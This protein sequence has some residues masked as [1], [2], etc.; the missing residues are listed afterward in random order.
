MGKALPWMLLAFTLGV[1]LPLQASVNGVL[2]QQIG[3]PV[4][5]AAVS[6]MV[7]TLCLI[8]YLFATRQSLPWPTVA[9]FNWTWLLSGA[10]G[11]CFVCL[12]LV[13]TPRLGFALSFGLVVAGQMT[14]AVVFDH[15]G[16]LG[17]PQHLVNL[18]RLIG[19]AAIVLG[20]VLIRRY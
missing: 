2:R 19:A 7:G 5:A 11:A 4:A 8:A 20:V 10:L 18:P 16:W 3:S 13:I 1:F 12:I 15:F 17:T 9:T 14:L 6:F